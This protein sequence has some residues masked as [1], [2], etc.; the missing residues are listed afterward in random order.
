MYLVTA[1]IL[2]RSSREN[3]IPRIR[4]AGDERELLFNSGAHKEILES[5]RDD[6]ECFE[7]FFREFQQWSSFP[8]NSQIGVLLNASNPNSDFSEL[9]FNMAAVFGGYFEGRNI[10]A[11]LRSQELAIDRKLNSWIVRSFPKKTKVGP[12]DSAK[13]EDR[14]DK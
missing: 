12:D 14:L 9:L 13:H 10:P 3:K 2:E 7:L 5:R 6:I 11:V 1:F 8:P 4:N